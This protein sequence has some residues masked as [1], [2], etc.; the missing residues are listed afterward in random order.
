MWTILDV[1]RNNESSLPVYHPNVFGQSRQRP[2]TWVPGSH[3]S[4]LPGL[5]SVPEA[6]FSVRALTPYT[7]SN[8]SFVQYCLHWLVWFSLFYLLASICTNKKS[9][10]HPSQ[11]VQ[12]VGSSQVLQG[13]G[14]E[15]WSRRIVGGCGQS[16]GAQMGGAVGQCSFLSF[17]PIPLFL[18]CNHVLTPYF[19]TFRG[20][21]P[22]YILWTQWW[23]FMPALSPSSWS[24]SF[25]G[26][27]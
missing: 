17:S 19:G 15:S 23:G 27:Y 25:F 16:V 14:F 11:V 13:F 22:N 26:P 20:W 1:C 6:Y 5:E 2:P 10:S 4:F 21:P 7:V 8:Y 3:S 18:F 24:S 9:C 12:L